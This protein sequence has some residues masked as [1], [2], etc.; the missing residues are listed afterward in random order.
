MELQPLG[1][2]GVSVSRLALGTMSFG[3][4]GNRD[5]DE[6]VRM[7]HTAL[8]AGINV[9]DTADVYSVGESEVI[10]GK[11]LTGRRDE[12]VLASKCF[13]PM[14]DDPNHRGGSRRWIM[15]AVEASLERLGTDHLDVY[16]LHK[17]DEDTDL[18]ESLGTIDDL[19]RQGKVRYGGVSTFPASWIVEAHRV[20]ERRGLAR[21][22]VEQPPYSIFTRAIEREVLPTTDRYGMGVLTWG[23]LDSGWLTGKY[24]ADATPAGS[25]AERWARGAERFD[26]SRDAVRRKHELVALLRELASVAGLTMPELAVAFCAEHPAVSSVIIGPRT[27][28]QLTSLLAAA[29]VHLDEAT[30]DAIDELVPPGEDVDP[31]FG[32]GW[33]PR[34]LTDPAR[35]RRSSGG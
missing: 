16:Y 35:R 17:L 32:Q 7:I 9:V 26:P 14:G 19:V 3:A 25:R 10:V 1:R 8:D 28:E 33:V 15:T 4:L 13:W 34:S 18:D 11:A 21:P 6:C 12:V 29:D 31:G 24:G 23:P 27:P 30:L 2:T 5:H 22:R 20:A